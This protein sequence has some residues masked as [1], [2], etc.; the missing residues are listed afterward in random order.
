MCLFWKVSSFP[1]RH[2]TFVVSH[3]PAT[4]KVPMQ[5]NIP[6]L[7]GETPSASLR[8]YTDCTPLVGTRFYLTSVNSF[9]FVDVDGTLSLFDLNKLYVVLRDTLTPS[10]LR[11]DRPSTATPPGK[12]SP[13]HLKELSYVLLSL[14]WPNSKRYRVGSTTY[15]LCLV[16]SFR[17]TFRSRHHVRTTTL[18]FLLPP[19][20]VLHSTQ[21][22]RGLN[23]R[24]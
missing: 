16:S 18:P 7:P 4:S 10:H 15:L 12:S 5:S 14:W 17:R 11:F 2:T 6:I 23:P 21:N 13:T 3:Y 19:S 22:L 1:L 8:L 9:L 20:I 24:K